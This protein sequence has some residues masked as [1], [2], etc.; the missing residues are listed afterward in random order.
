MVKDSQPISCHSASGINCACPGTS[1]SSAQAVPVMVQ[2]AIG[3]ECSN[4]VHTEEQLRMND[5]YYEKKD[6]RA[7]KK[8]VSAKIQ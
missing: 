5:C 1:E 4:V 2:Y 8:E 3:T 7:C 6:W